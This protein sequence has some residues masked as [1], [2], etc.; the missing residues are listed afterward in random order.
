MRNFVVVVVVVVFYSSKISKT[1][2]RTSTSCYY[3]SDSPSGWKE[4]R[5]LFYAIYR[6]FP[7][8][9]PKELQDKENQELCSHVTHSLQEDL[10]SCS[11]SCYSRYCHLIWDKCLWYT[12]EMN[13]CSCFW[14]VICVPLFIVLLWNLCVLLISWCCLCPVL[15]LVNCVL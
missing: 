9:I 2:S 8:E 12:I 15:C 13:L 10:K 7:S 1:S 4:S 3:S 6:V 14:K 5:Y 11:R